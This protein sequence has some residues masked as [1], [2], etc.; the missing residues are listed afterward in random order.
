MEDPNLVPST[1]SRKKKINEVVNNLDLLTLP[2][3]V[4]NTDQ[5]VNAIVIDTVAVDNKEHI[6]IPFVGSKHISIQ[7]FAFSRSNAVKNFVKL[8]VDQKQFS[9]SSIKRVV[10]HVLVKSHSVIGQSVMKKPSGLHVAEMFDPLVFQPGSFSLLRG[11]CP[12]I[13]VQM[14]YNHRAVCKLCSGVASGLSSDCYFYTMHKCITHGWK[15]PV[16]VENI[17]AVYRTSGNYPAVTLYDESTS[18]EFQ[19]MV[20]HGVLI[21][22]KQYIGRSLVMNPLGVVVKKSDIVRAHVLVDVTVKDQTSL[23]LA[24]SKLLAMV[25]PQPKIK[26]RITSDY[27]ASGVN[28]AAYS[29]SFQYPGL[30]D[31]IRLIKRGCFLGKTDITRYFHSFPIA[32]ESRY[33]GALEFKG[34]YYQYAR[35]AFGFTTCPYYCSTWSAE[36]KLWLSSILH[37]E[38]AHMMDDWLIED[39]SESKAKTKLSKVRVLFNDI[40]LVI[41]PDK[42][43]IGQVLTFLGVRLDT[44]NMTLRFE[45]TQAKGMKLELITYLNQLVGGNHLDHSTIRHTCGKLNWYSEIVQSGRLHLRS[46]WY[47]EKYRGNLVTPTFNRL[48]ADTQW[49]IDLLQSWEEGVSS[50]IEYSILSAEE[51]LVNPESIMILQSDASGT[52]GFGYYFGYYRSEKVAWVSKRWT[53][54]HIEHSSHTDEL[55][56]LADYLDSNCMAR[57]AILVWVT[58]SESAMWSVNKGRCFEISGEEVLRRILNQ[59]DHYRLQIIALW[60][61]RELNELADYLS[62]LSFCINRDQVSGSWSEQN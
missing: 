38:T 20:N 7:D 27:T 58:D 11:S 14:V 39:E 62:H 25:P 53:S 1:N 45:P 10:H 21:E 29:P 37:I 56:A 22:S 46:W 55:W 28:R 16:V 5:D 36:F 30:Q 19:D 52:D 23:H 33:L 47:Y 26:A 43:E 41:N 51:L 54:D 8:L 49:W 61:P 59:C 32:Y 57:D 60:V 6:S 44:V 34:K 15:M 4:Q 35:C 2:S 17:S 40:G 3:L 42:D 24:N 50:G 13:P 18:K 12:L 48:L 9:L 31:G